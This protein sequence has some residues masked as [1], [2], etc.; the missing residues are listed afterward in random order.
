MHISD[1]KN[2][3]SYFLFLNFKNEDTKTN[4]GE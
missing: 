4:R 3:F 2:Y 1:S